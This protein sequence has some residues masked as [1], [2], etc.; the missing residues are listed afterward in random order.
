M[1]EAKTGMERD[2]DRDGNG[3]RD[4]ETV[5]ESDDQ[6]VVLSGCGEHLNE[7]FPF[8]LREQVPT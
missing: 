4:R 5:S 3:D 7:L 1:A 2:R 6:S 8:T